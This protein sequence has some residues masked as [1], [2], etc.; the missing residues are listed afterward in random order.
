MEMAFT[1]HYD[2]VIGVLHNMFVA[3][4]EG[5]EKTSPTTSRRRAQYPSA[6]PHDGG[7]VRRP[8]GGGDGDARGAEGSTPSA[9]TT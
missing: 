3:V 4:F 5:L 8:L 2:E 9:S 1:Q 6:A 7:A